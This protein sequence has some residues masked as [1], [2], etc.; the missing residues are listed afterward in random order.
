M[1]QARI[2]NDIEALGY[3]VFEC[4]MKNNYAFSSPDGYVA[5]KKDL[6]YQERTMA[7]GHEYGHCAT[8]AFYYLTSPFETKERAEE[9]ARR[10][11]TLK[12]IPYEGLLVALQHGLETWEIAEYYGVPDSL[13]EKT[14]LFYKD[15]LGLSFDGENL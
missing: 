13:I 8:G 6:P 7:L 12:Y 3:D 14:Y 4:P 15:T 9:R 1:L 2:L 11:A 10:A 5:V